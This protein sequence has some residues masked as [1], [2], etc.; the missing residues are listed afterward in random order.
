MLPKKQSWAETRI[1]YAKMARLR[2]QIKFAALQN[3]VDKFLCSAYIS[4]IKE[5]LARL[6]VL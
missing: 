4:V 3:I 1:S 2:C 5:G 6:A